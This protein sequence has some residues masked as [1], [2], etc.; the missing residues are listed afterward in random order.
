MPGM[1][2]NLQGM[3]RLKR[4]FERIEDP[5]MVPLMV[6]WIDIIRTDNR[7]GILAGLDKD[8]VPMAPVTYR[9]KEPTI[10]IG[11]SSSARL[12]LGQRAGRKRDLVA[13]GD[14]PWA[15]G[16]NN[17]LTSAEYRALTGPAL[18]P[19]ESFSRAITNL[20]L[21][22]FEEGRGKASVWGFWDEVVTPRGDNFLHYLFDGKGR[23]GDIPARDL[24]GVR[25]EG[26]RR[27]RAA[28]RA[29]MIEIVRTSG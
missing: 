6:S 28:L 1:I 5:D 8:G 26:M 23:Y 3:D 24:R 27:A 11:V 16:L 29:W 25:P 18:A 2:E 7:D 20:K 14:G 22:Y 21:G 4:R 19:R 10:K 15:S 12:G 9:P 13:G 17:N